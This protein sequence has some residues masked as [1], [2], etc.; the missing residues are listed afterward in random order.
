MYRI[1]ARITSTSTAPSMQCHKRG[2]RHTYNHYCHGGV[3]KGTREGAAK[4]GMGENWGGGTDLSFT[5]SKVLR[6]PNPTLFY[7]VPAE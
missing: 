4:H 1:A 2:S 3:E 7:S 6:L 5:G